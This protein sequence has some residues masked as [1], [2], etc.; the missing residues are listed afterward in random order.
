MRM[1]RRG[2]TAAVCGATMA[3]AESERASE[4]CVGGGPKREWPK[5][6]G[7]KRRH[8]AA[9]DVDPDD[10]RDAAARGT[11]AGERA[12]GASSVRS[13]HAEAA[14]R[15]REDASGSRRERDVSVRVEWTECDACVDDDDEHQRRAMREWRSVADRLSAGARA[16]DDG[17]EVRGECEERVGCECVMSERTKMSSAAH[18][19]TTGRA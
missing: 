6:E 7:P 17:G 12:R 19:T 15:E 13:E 18:G 2:A 10:D 4:Y 1:Q 9:A 14:A 11:C 8:A 16:D 3:R 5:R